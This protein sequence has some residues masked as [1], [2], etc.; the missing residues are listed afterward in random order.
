MANNGHEIPEWLHQLFIQVN[1]EDVTHATR[2]ITLADLNHLINFTRGRELNV[3]TV[4][5]LCE[6]ASK[7]SGAGTPLIAAAL[8]IAVIAFCFPGTAA[9]LCSNPLG[10]IMNNVTAASIASTCQSIW[11]SNA[12][13]GLLQRAAMGGYGAPIVAG[14]LQDAS[15]AN[16]AYFSPQ[17][18]D[19]WQLDYAFEAVNHGHCMQ[20][21]VLGLLGEAL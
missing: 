15:A 21:E 10:F 20:R 5:K 3:D 19:R 18:V 6:E 8:I 1:L 2:R 16:A 13:F 12:L 11:R 7:L 4:T 9:A 14:M 17:A